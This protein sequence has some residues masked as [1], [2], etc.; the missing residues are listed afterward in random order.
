MLPEETR[1][2]D[3]VV[4]QDPLLEEGPDA[5]RR[6]GLRR[7]RGAD[8]SRRTIART[9]ARSRASPVARFTRWVYLPD[10]VCY[11]DFDT[12]MTPHFERG[13]IF[14]SAKKLIFAHLHEG[15]EGAAAAYAAAEQIH[16][17]G[18]DDRSGAYPPLEKPT[19]GS[20]AQGHRL[21]EKLDGQA[22]L[23]VV[24]ASWPTLYGLGVLALVLVVALRRVPRVAADRDPP[25]AYFAVS[26]GT[27]FL[28]AVIASRSVEPFLTTALDRF[29][30][31]RRATGSCAA[32]WREVTVE[33]HKPQPRGARAR[34]RGREGARVGR[35]GRGA[36][37]GPQAARGRGDLA[38]D[39]SERG[40]SRRGLQDRLRGV[41]ALERT[42]AA[43]ERGAGGSAAE[44]GG[45][46][47]SGCTG[48]RGGSPRRAEAAAGDFLKQPFRVRLE[49]PPNPPN[50]TE[51]TEM[52]F[53]VFGVFGG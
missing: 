10:N 31:A 36:R 28:L 44:R 12:D 40:R 4:V 45:P 34:G 18:T 9:R 1:R 19:Q 38:E 20:G 16:T 47:G 2:G 7:L 11:T 26:A 33:S 35:R 8:A 49:K 25:V 21:F 23:R 3:T 14:E 17:M 39:G 53:G 29:R 30:W 22:K 37:P 42:A 13:G 6:H 48:R 46:D 24:Y 15:S 27:C 32:V 51:T 43:R 50:A 52:R 5:L 41:D